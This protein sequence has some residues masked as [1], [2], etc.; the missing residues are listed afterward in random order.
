[1]AL[2]T[3][4]SPND[5]EALRVFETAILNVAH[6]E[7][8]DLDAKL[9]LATEEISQDVLDVLLD[10]TRA[11]DPRG[12]ERR[13]IGVADV[14]VTPQ[15]KRW[16]ALHTLAVVYRDAYNNHRVIKR[17][18]KDFKNHF[19]G[20]RDLSFIQFWPGLI[21]TTRDLLPIIVKA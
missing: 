3:D 18:V 2:L 16:Q 17:V 19:P 9:G 7:T 4:G 20:L 12:K 8:I 6:V 14:V 5:T 21:D 13:R 15:M 1:M 11:H 10:H